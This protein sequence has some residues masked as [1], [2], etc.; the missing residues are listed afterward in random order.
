MTT[1]LLDITDVYLS[2]SPNTTSRVPMIATMSAS[3]WFLPA[4]G[5]SSRQGLNMSLFHYLLPIWLVR[6]R[7]RKPGALILHL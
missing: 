7:W 1:K 3:M 6:A 5:G 2:T 4:I